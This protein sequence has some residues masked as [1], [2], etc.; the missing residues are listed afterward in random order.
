M[1]THS[2]TTYSLTLTS[3]PLAILTVSLFTSNVSVLVSLDLHI[4]QDTVNLIASLT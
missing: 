2:L 1:N 3:N 4:K